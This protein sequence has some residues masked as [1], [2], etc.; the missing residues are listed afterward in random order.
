MYGL[1]P[2]FVLHVGNIEPRKDVPTLAAACREAGVPLVLAGGSIATVEV[3]AG[4]RPLGYVDAARLPALYAAA[5]AVAYVS[6]YEGFGLP[7]LEAMACGAAV[8]ATRVGALPDLVDGA[9]EWVPAGD[10]GA[11][12]AVIR[13]LVVDEEHR[14]ALVDGRI[15]G[16]GAALLG[17]DGAAHRR[18]LQVTRRA[19][20]DAAV[21]PGPLRAAPTRAVVAVVTGETLLALVLGAAFLGERGFWLDEAFTWST[22]DRPFTDLLHLLVTREGFQI[23]HSLLLWPLNQISSTPVMLRSPSVLAFAA[24]VPAVWLA[25]RR[26]FD[27]RAGLCAGMLLAVNGLALQYAQEAR[28]YALAMMLCAYAAACLAGEVNGPTRGGRRVWIVLSALAV[29][30]HGFAVLAIGAQVVS[31]ILLPPGRVRRRLVS[32]AAHI[33]LLAAPAVVLPLLHAGRADGG[34]WNETTSLSTLREL[35]WL[36]AGRTVTAIPVYAIGGGVALLAA[37]GAWKR[38]GRSDVVWRHGMPLMWLVPPLVVPLVIAMLRPDLA[39]PIRDAEPRRPRRARRLRPDADRGA[40]VV[41]GGARRRLR[42]HGSGRT[43]GHDY[44]GV[45]GTDAWTHS[46]EMVAWMSPEVEH[47]DGIVFVTDR[48]R[49]PFE[50]WAR[51]TDIVAEAVPVYPPQPW[52]EYRTGDQP[53]DAAVPSE[54]EADETIADGPDRLWV[55][56]AHHDRDV[57]DAYVNR[58]LAAYEVQRHVWFAGEEEIRLLVRR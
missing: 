45:P 1:P 58:L 38:H 55:V 27:D 39:L 2:E 24:A 31:V 56:A 29:Y 14:S 22:V 48:A 28:S 6:R 53:P 25:G 46:E 44:E 37:L 36:L 26:L 7:P 41:G 13:S 11:Q 40:Q 43:A 51:H 3:P 8:V 19:V 9:V 5:S 16:G 54:G 49:F 23:L 57:V 35:V 30:A 42:S 50:F 33:G 52:G 32:G 4:A 12:A 47:G 17:G 21:G 18:R 34:A 10:P 20:S 15:G